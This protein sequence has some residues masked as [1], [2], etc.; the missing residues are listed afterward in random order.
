MKPVSLTQSIGGY[1][2][3]FSLLAI[4]KLKIA[5]PEMASI[6]TMITRTIILLINLVL[7]E[8]GLFSQIMSVGSVTSVI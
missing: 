2:I 7:S 1:F 3:F 5:Y 6:N 4:D 8:I